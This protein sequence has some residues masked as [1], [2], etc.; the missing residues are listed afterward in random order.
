MGQAVL[1]ISEVLVA[2]M[3]SGSSSPT[4]DLGTETVEAV[5]PQFSKRM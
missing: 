4:G 3:S 2:A 5:E 1:L